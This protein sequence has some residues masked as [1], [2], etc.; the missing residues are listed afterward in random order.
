VFLLPF[1]FERFERLLTYTEPLIPT[2]VVRRV[3]DD[4]IK[5]E[6]FSA[7]KRR[8]DVFGWIMMMFTPP[9][10]D[11]LWRDEYPS[12]PLAARLNAGTPGAEFIP[13]PVRDAAAYRDFLEAALEHSDQVVREFEAV[14]EA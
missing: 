8:Y 6:R 11:V 13:A 2:E 12:L 14:L 1:V 5:R 9:A 3:G 10:R 4:Q 7:L